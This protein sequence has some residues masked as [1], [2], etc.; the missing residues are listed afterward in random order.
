LSYQLKT[1]IRSPSARVRKLSRKQ[2]AGCRAACVCHAE[3]LE[4]FAEQALELP[5]VL[6]QEISMICRS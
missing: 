6:E 1:F 2:D 4:V 3:S 5:E